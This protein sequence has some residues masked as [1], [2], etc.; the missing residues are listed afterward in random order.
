MKLGELYKEAEQFKQ[1]Q[2]GLSELLELSNIPTKEKLHGSG[3]SQAHYY[4]KLAGKNFTAKQ[5]LGIFRKI[6]ES[7]NLEMIKNKNY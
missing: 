3:I 6:I 2:K 5:L 1:L 7:S 4:R